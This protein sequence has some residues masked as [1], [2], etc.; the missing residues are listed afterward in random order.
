MS[1]QGKRKKSVIEFPIPPA[2]ESKE[3]LNMKVPFSLKWRTKLHLMFLES[4]GKKTTLTD[5]VVGLMEAD[6]SRAER[7][8]SR[9]R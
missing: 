4:E 1:A 6:L 8:R 5:Y 2:D 3:A 7:I 9:R